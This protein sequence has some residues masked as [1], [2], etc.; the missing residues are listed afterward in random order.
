[1]EQQNQPWV[2]NDSIVREI[3]GRSDTILLVFA[4]SAAEFALNRAV[5]WLFFTGRIP[6]DPIG[7]LFATARFGQEIAFVDAA[8]AQRTLDRINR[9]HAGVERQRGA[10]IPAWSH[11]DVLYMLIDYS[12]RAYRLLKRPLRPS[13]Q[14]DLYDV[15]R[16]VGEGLLIPDLPPDYESWREDRAAHLAR[17]LVVS[18]YTTMLYA[19]YRRH[20]GSWRYRLLLQLQGLLA[21]P[22]VRT[23]LRLDPQPP[24][25]H[26]LRAYPL[27]TRLGLRPLAQ[28]LMIPPRYLT[29]VRRLDV[30]AAAITPGR[31]ARV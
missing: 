5:D 11:R 31:L 17:N 20:L 23:L 4:G 21:P 14:A 7:R 24:A 18:D 15:F 30:P 9:I 2:A 25:R 1:M 29:D 10:T 28:R 3:W 27:A 13:E 16:R 6:D 12:E 22:R 26:L 19:Q 8:T